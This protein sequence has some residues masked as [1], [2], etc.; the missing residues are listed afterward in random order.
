MNLYLVRNSNE[1]AE[2]ARSRTGP[3]VCVYRPFRWHWVSEGFI[4]GKCRCIYAGTRMPRE[5]IERAQRYLA[6]A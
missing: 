5:A 4:D 3:V 2:V 1:A 6:H